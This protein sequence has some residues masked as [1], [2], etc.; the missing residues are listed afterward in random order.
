MLAMHESEY[1]IN[2][3]RRYAKFVLVSSVVIQWSSV[4]VHKVLDALTDY[5][6]GSM[7]ESSF[8]FRSYRGCRRAV[9]AG[10]RDLGS[11]E[12]LVPGIVMDVA[13]FATGLTRARSADNHT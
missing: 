3:Y 4:R 7:T 11:T 6:R 12:T 1:G 2:L 9:A 13:V 8:R 10:R 5:L